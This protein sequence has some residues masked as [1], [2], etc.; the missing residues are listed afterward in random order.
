MVDDYRR[1]ECAIRYLED[2][3]E[4]QPGLAEIAKHIGLSPFHFQRLFRRWAGISP[5]RFLEYLTISH[6]KKLL[7]SNHSVMDT[8]YE[9]GLSSPG[10]L[11]DHFIS[12]EAVA[13]G[14]F[15]KYGEGLMLL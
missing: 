6:A 4:A 3:S 12:I 11:H 13:P 8:A 9:L 7:R 1:I 5:K 2:N 15:K 10:R 14:E